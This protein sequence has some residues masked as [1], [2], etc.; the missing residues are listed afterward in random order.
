MTRADA[1]EIEVMLARSIM[2]ENDGP[3]RRKGREWRDI[4]TSHVQKKQDDGLPGSFPIAKQE[5]ERAATVLL[6][7][8]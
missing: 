8:V 7:L 4:I 1:L 2:I 3:S 5:L 6:G